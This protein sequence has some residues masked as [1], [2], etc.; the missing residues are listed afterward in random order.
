[1]M[2]GTSQKAQEFQQFERPFFSNYSFQP[3]YKTSTETTQFNSETLESSIFK[4][5]KKSPDF[6]TQDLEQHQ[7]YKFYRTKSENNR[8]KN[9][10]HFRDTFINKNQIKIKENSP[11][12]NQISIRNSSPHSLENSHDRNHSY[13]RDKEQFFE[14]GKYNS[15]PRNIKKSRI[16]KYES[17]PFHNKNRSYRRE[18]KQETITS[19]RYNS[20]HSRSSYK[21]YDSYRPQIIS[22][23]NH[24][25]KQVIDYD[26]IQ[27]S[28]RFKR[29]SKSPPNPRSGNNLNNR[30]MIKYDE[31]LTSRSYKEGDFFIDTKDGLQYYSMDYSVPEQR[32]N[33][34]EISPTDTNRQDDLH[35][36]S[37]EANGHT[38]HAN[39]NTQSLLSPHTPEPDN[40]IEKKSNSAKQVQIQESQ[41]SSDLECKFPQLP[42]SHQ[43]LESMNKMDSQISETENLVCFL[44]KYSEEC[45]KRNFF[46][47]ID[48]TQQILNQS[49]EIS[50][51][52]HNSVEQF[53]EPID[54]KEKEN[55]LDPFQNKLDSQMV[56][57]IEKKIKTKMLFEQ[58]LERN[59]ET[60]FIQCECRWKKKME[61]SQP[62]KSSRICKISTRSKI[63]NSVEPTEFGFVSQQI[64]HNNNYDEEQKLQ[65][66]TSV[67]AEV[68]PM[69]LS[70]KDRRARRF[71]NTNGKVSSEECK[72][73]LEEQS[74]IWTDEEKEIFFDKY[75]QFPKDFPKIAQFINKKNTRQVIQFYYLNR[76]KL[77][78]SETA[79][80]L[81]RTPRKKVIQEG[82][83]TTPR[84]TPVLEKRPQEIKENKE[85]TNEETSS[86]A[87]LCGKP[88][89]KR[90]QK[91]KTEISNQ[92]TRWKAKEK[93][94]FQSLFQKHGPNFDLISTFLPSKSSKQCQEFFLKNQK[95][96]TGKNFWSENEKKIFIDQLK[97][98]GR[99]WNAISIAIISKTP[100]QVKNFFQNNKTKL[101]LLSILLAGGH[102]N[103][104]SS[105]NRKKRKNDD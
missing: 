91:E 27:G 102:S 50:K 41:K 95:R 26:V 66:F 101:D 58:L 59:L 30:E 14:N 28:P 10:R 19:K 13:S 21:L 42:T 8:T 2:M 60:N 52:I 4:Q 38:Q 98:K 40:Q 22:H 17:K 36:F 6:E 87:A 64:I 96:K 24:Q 3:N 46:S 72:K 18:S 75:K 31:E 81:Q 15:Y 16:K 33:S 83:P 35:K 62:R 56:S 5:K 48:Q 55:I 57:K 32:F 84:K 23:S 79:E 71:L 97:E 54:D 20:Y 12:E 99:D 94:E 1:M 44:R 92:R 43:V 103:P 68:P 47:I 77:S 51:N 67:S 88:K 25:S 70:L 29:N 80:Q 53:L 9:S 86:F 100:D 73:L 61:K 78:K 65:Y 85:K 49:L 7:K 93:Q 90:K 11:D 104:L 37:P 105:R 89:V 76:F 69:I 74:K 34:S 39:N 82:A 63:R 45:Q